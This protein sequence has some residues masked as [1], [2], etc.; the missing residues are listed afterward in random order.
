MLLD[1]VNYS[2]SCIKEKNYKQLQLDRDTQ[3]FPELLIKLLEVPQAF[4]GSPYF[5]MRIFLACNC[6]AG[7]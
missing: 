6:S 3:L 2:S 5:H 4:K 7:C 1:F